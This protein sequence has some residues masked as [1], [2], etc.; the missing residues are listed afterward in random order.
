MYTQNTYITANRIKIFPSN[1][2]ENEDTF[3]Y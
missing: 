3:K 1:S 2:S